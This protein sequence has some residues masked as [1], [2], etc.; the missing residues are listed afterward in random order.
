[1][2][3]YLYQDMSIL[4][5]DSGSPLVCNGV[6]AGI[7]SGVDDDCSD[8]LLPNLYTEVSKFLPWIDQILKENGC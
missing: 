5:G 4:Q 8:P 7:P 1:M 3:L 2:Y 6:A